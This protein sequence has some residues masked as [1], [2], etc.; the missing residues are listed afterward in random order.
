[1]SLSLTAENSIDQYRALLDVSESIAL[2]RDLDALFADLAQRL[3]GALRFDYLNLVL[4]VPERNTMR[5]RVLASTQ[6]SDSSFSET[7]VE[8]SPSGLVWQTQQ[9]LIIDDIERDTRYPKVMRLLRDHGVRSCCVLPLTTA[10]RR[11]GAMGL[12]GAAPSS[13][14]HADLALLTQAARQVAVAVENVLNYESAQCY[15]RE[16]ARERDRLRVVLD[17]TNAMVGNL[18]LRELFRAV[19]ELLRRLIRHEYASLV[20][21]DPVQGQLRLE[22]LDFPG[23]DSQIHEAHSASAE[24][25]PAAE[26]LRAREP[27]LWNRVDAERYSSDVMR[28]LLDAGLQSAVCIPLLRGDRAL[29]TLNVAS[30]RDANFAREDVELLVQIGNELAIAVENALAFRQIAELKDRLAEEKLYLED[31]IRTEYDFEEIVGESHSLKRVLRDVET[32]APT[33]ST[34]LIQG[35]SGTGKELIARA[36]HNLGGRRERT[37]VKVN[38]A[39]IPTGLL[40]SE[41]FGHERGAFTGAISQKIG[42]FELAHQGT[43]FLDE[44]GDIPLELQPKLLRVLQ[45]REFERLGSNRTVKVDIRLVTATNRDLGQMIAD[46]QFR[47]DLY[48]R[49]NVFPITL[50]PLRERRE[51]IPLLVRYFTQKYARRMNRRIETIPAEAMEALANGNWP[52]NVRELENF[53]ERAVILTRGAALHVPLAELRNNSDTGAPVAPLSTMEQAE[54]EHIRRALEESKWVIGGPAGAAARLGLKRTTL[55]SRMRKLGIRRGAGQ[56]S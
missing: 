55:Q 6:P 53:I 50:P 12:G 45:E 9:P 38:C 11:L 27:L 24:D 5:L 23:G 30:M 34:V 26:A 51:D 4:H 13:F 3:R 48:Y 22:A 31:E 19:S 46:R 39:A 49:L 54:R 10:Q 36:I 47:E 28:R 44:I 16:L 32:V 8:E 2:N 40:E 42:R 15:Q 14:D 1:M 41:L 21:V 25:S 7:P 29:G 52:G 20:L 18:D 35:E 56:G 37:F 17:V 43:L 33:D